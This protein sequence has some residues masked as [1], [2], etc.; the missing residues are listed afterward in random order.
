MTGAIRSS[1]ARP[2]A[3]RRSSGGA[4]A[5]RRTREFTLGGPRARRAAAP[6]RSTPGP[7]R[8]ESSPCSALCRCCLPSW[9][10]RRR[11]SP[12]GVPT[13]RAPGAGRRHPWRS[14][15]TR[16]P[17]R[18][19]RTRGPIRVTGSVTNNDDAP[20]TTVN[21]YAFIGRDPDDDLRRA[22]GGRRLRAR[23][24]R[25][26][27]DHRAQRLRHHRAD[28]PRAERAVL[29][30]GAALGDQRQRAR[31]LL[32][33]RARA[34]E[35]ARRAAHAAPTAGPHLPPA[36][37]P[38]EASRW[39]PRWS[40]PCADAVTFTP[41]TGASPRSPAGPGRSRR[42]AGCA[43]WSTSGLGRDRARSPGW[44]TR[45]SGRR[46]RAGGRQPAALARAGRGGRGPR[47]GRRR[48]L[49]GPH[50]QR[51]GRRPTP[52]KAPAPRPRR[53]RRRP[54]RRRTPG[55]SGSRSRSRRAA[56]LTL[57]YGDVDVP[58]AAKR[59]PSTHGRARARS[60]GRQQS[61]RRSAA[62]SPPAGT[63]TRPGCAS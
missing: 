14:P 26:G 30:P 41:A 53:S 34:R 40:S 43:R 31:R 3:G 33:R 37:A 54:S 48:G 28:R 63:S 15:S 10:S 2:S 47:R 27:P 11:S 24:G 25:R 19:S 18:T 57:P 17:R 6:P 12:P 5:G 50:R 42:A 44:S 61:R 32:V 49:P 21:V 39:T 51:R 20:W 45:P 56:V 59:G 46:A 1:S 22:G 9:R 4:G 13:R 7:R 52:P 35:P 38:D 8:L 29:G 16:S 36:R 60:D 55:W 62:V 58:A 23:P